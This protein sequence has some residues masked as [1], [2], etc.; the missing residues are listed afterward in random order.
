M[1][2]CSNITKIDSNILMKEAKCVHN[3]FSRVKSFKKT[4][5]HFSVKS[6]EN[7]SDNRNQVKECII[8]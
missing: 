4:T 3:V 5:L 6:C 2:M 1:S 8:I 7:L